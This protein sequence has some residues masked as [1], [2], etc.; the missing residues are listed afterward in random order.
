MK[1]KKIL[2]CQQCPKAIERDEIDSAKEKNESAPKTN[3]PFRRG[4]NDSPSSVEDKGQRDRKEQAPD[5][6]MIFIIY[7]GENIVLENAITEF[8][9]GV[10]ENKS[11][12]DH[13]RYDRHGQKK[14]R[15]AAENLAPRFAAGLSMS[16]CVRDSRTG[17]NH[18]QQ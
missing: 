15:G 17:K 2:P 8:R 6:R 18:Q 13:G 5:C 16:H 1:G 12:H 7:T 4:A 14:R 10:A 3:R 11:R 9:P